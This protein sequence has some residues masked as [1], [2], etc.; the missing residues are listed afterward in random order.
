MKALGTAATGMMAQAR[1]V[2]VI[3]NNIANANTPGFKSGRAMFSDLVY[4]SMS[5]EGA[6]TSDSGTMTPVAMDIGMGVRA[7]GVMREN[8]QGSFT[9]TAGD[10][11]LAIDGKGFFVVN[12]PDGTIAYTR[13]GNFARS[14]EGEMV[15]TDGHQVAPG[16]VLPEGTRD[17]VVS[18]TGFVSAY[19]G[20]E[21][22]PQ[23]IGQLTLATFVN[24]AGL[25]AVGDNLLLE[26]EASGAAV[27]GAPGDEGFGILRQGYLESSNVD[28]VKQMTA[29]ILAQRTY[30][31]NSKAL[32][33]A[34]E[35]L[36]T[37]NQIR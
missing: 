15:T 24:E 3:A 31:M 19:V 29:L 21:T 22:V 17:V 30:D 28:T 20:N 7:T 25:K 26:T 14:P 8:T 33:A 13:A 11:D 34:D 6:V 16:I 18:T 23:E 4:Q 27:T 12:R 2:D 36:Q 5:R 10:F 32:T 37:A 1:N 9:E 35:M